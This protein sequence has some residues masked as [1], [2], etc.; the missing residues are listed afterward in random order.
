MQVTKIVELLSCE[1]LPNAGVI[2]AV[3]DLARLRLAVIRPSGGN[4]MQRN[5]RRRQRGAARVWLAAA[6]AVLVVVAIF[7]GA[8]WESDAFGDGT[9]I[10]SFEIEERRTDFDPV[11][12]SVPASAKPEGSPTEELQVHVSLEEIFRSERPESLLGQRIEIPSLQVTQLTGDASFYVR[13][14]DG[15]PER[16]YLVVV[17]PEATHDVRRGQL[18]T[19]SGTIRGVPTEPPSEWGLA[20]EEIVDLHHHRVYL[21][22]HRVAA[23][24]RPE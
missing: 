19:V 4:E 6:G 22:A 2:R 9:S 15:S 11:S 3:V 10:G 7:V 21:H 12:Y 20:A 5:A 18:V 23:L 14:A 1:N 8:A 16:E 17:D 24:A 13:A